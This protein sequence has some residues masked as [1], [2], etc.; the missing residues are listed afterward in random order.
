MDTE[1]L[2]GSVA[3]AEKRIAR[4]LS[5]MEQ[6]DDSIDLLRWDAYALA[7]LKERIQS[8]DSV[9]LSQDEKRILNQ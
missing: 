8:G 3:T 1:T 6:A 4:A 7:R 9:T 5:G 2:L